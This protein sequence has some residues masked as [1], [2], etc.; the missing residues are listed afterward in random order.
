MKDI[1]I[2]IDDWRLNCRATGII[3]HNNKVLL[4][5]NTNDTYY[6]L[7]G[8][9]VKTGE[10]SAEAVVREFKEEIGKDIEIVQYVSTIENFFKTPKFK[11]HE[12]TF[13]YQLEFTDENDKLIEDTIYNIEG[14]DEKDVQYEWIDLS[15]ID[16]Y[17]IKPKAIK[18][19]I[20]N[21]V[22]PVH[23][24]NNEI[25]DNKLY[26]KIYNDEQIRKIYSI[27]DD[28]EEKNEKAW[29]HH[30]FNHVNNVTKMT[31]QILKSLK[32]QDTQLIEEAK[33]A[34]ILHDTGVTEG[35]QNHA[36]RS[37][38]FAKKYLKENNIKLK[39][40]NLVLE[41]IKNHSD[42]FDT[43]NI[44]QLALIF[45]D[46]LD[47]KYTRVTKNGL[48][49]EG[50]RQMQFIQDILIDIC[51]KNMTVKFICDQKLNKKELEEYYFMKK[52]GNAI[53]S[54]SNKFE[55]GYKVY[56]NDVEWKEIL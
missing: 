9:R 43:N 50:M 40:E 19:I 10:S 48:D 20:K 52:V 55:L 46:K 5:H 27:I 21:S 28:V 16:N 22:F 18:D 33:I 42:G 38:E 54:F 1:T 24:I 39:N 34:A 7:V 17:I 31:E 11:Y 23:A 29:A 30:N 13:V 37:Y 4:H 36:E 3:I 25:A 44:I 51:N 6:A 15:N 12:I 8:G 45:A 2:D 41:A 47:I 56:Y 32:V 35:K 49:V 53:K 26:D 14:G